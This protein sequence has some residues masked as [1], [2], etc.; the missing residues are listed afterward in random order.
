VSEQWRLNSGQHIPTD[1][2]APSSRAEMTGQASSRPAAGTT[3]PGTAAPSSPSPSARS[4]N[5]ATAAP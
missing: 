5:P 4:T 1:L 2:G 3:P